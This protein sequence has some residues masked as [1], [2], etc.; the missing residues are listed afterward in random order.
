[1]KLKPLLV[2]VMLTATVSAQQ[3]RPE[4]DLC[5]VPPGAQPLLP[6]KLL[7]GMG[8]TDM[9]VTTRSA[10]AQKFFNQ[11]VAQVHSFWF[12][13]AERSFLQAATL[14]PDMAM[15]YWGMALSAAGDYR[16]AFQLLR[17]SNDGGR[18]AATPD[19][20]NNADAVQRTSTGAAVSPQIRARENIAK[21]MDLRSKVT[22]RE[23]LYIESQSA[24]RNPPA[25]APNGDAQY[26]NVL[27]TLVT[28]YPDDLEAKSMLG[29]ALLDGFD[30]VTK[31]PRTH[32]LEGIRMLEEVVAKDDN[33][34]GAHHYLIHGYEGSTS[35]EKAWHACERYAALVTNIPHA[36]HMPGH[37]YAQSDKIDEAIASFTAAAENELRWLDNDSLYPNGHHGHNV[38]FL[39]HSLNLDGRYQ[40]SIKWAKHLL[41]LKETP[42]ERRG[43]NQRGPY[44]QGYYGLVKTLVRF[45][46][47]N[48]ILDESTVPVYDQPTQRAWRHWARGLALAARGDSAG[49]K[50]EAEGMDTQIAA[51]TPRAPEPLRIGLQELQGT[52][53]ARFGDRAKGFS[54]MQQAAGREAAL[55]YTEPPSYP[56]PV[57]EGMANTALALGD[58]D[59]AVA[60]YRVAL[61]REPGSGRAY[62]GLA[63]ALAGIGQSDEARRTRE[64][65][66]KAW[67]KADADLPQIVKLKSAT[68]A[69]E[70]R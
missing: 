52:I 47:W 63:D 69:G 58:F 44:R 10:E 45:E 46:K 62:F 22:E 16:P 51:I 11:G 29:L 13:E 25:G 60:S 64:K 4:A 36:L 61:A 35:P 67:D 50:A 23:R 5:A 14:D 6:A 28:K 32:T 7:P 31:A 27:R 30:P 55:L 43:A 49:A 41:D 18:T 12:Q 37:I 26:I 54:L 3:K 39:I 59:M 1:M 19:R 40:D 70:K 24:R 56:R 21:A 17:D 53:E 38:H 42:T 9:T 15:A 48:E 57:V 2:V 65:A 8:A 33:H 20:G 68:A 34:F 66:A